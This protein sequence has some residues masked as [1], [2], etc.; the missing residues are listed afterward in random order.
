M[1]TRVSLKYFVN[2]CRNYTEVFSIFF[3]TSVSLFFLTAYL[4]RFSTN[5]ERHFLTY[6]LSRVSNLTTYLRTMILPLKIK[7]GKNF[8]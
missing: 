7:T 6:I 8:K 1:E 3:L 5:N 4:V 2:G